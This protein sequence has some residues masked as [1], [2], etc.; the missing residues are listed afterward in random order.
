MLTLYSP[1]LS[2]SIENVLYRSKHRDTPADRLW[3]NLSYTR[4]LLSPR[5]AENTQQSIGHQRV[6]KTDKELT[7]ELDFPGVGQDDLKVDI[8]P[9]GKIRIEAKRSWSPRVEEDGN[10]DAIASAPPHQEN[11]SEENYSEIFVVPQNVDKSAI[12]ATYAHGVLR[13]HFPLKSEEETQS[14]PVRLAQ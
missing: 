5:F 3:K 6:N 11:Y 13:V 14:I 9:E 4:P 2:N 12:S 8:L 1:F 7:L 10:G